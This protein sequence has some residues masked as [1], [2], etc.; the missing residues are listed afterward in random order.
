MGKRRIILESLRKVLDGA[1]P[2]RPELKPIIVNRYTAD[3]VIKLF[4][5]SQRKRSLPLFS[6]LTEPETITIS[7][8]GISAERS[9][10]LIIQ[11][12][13]LSQRGITTSRSSDSLLIGE[14]F[15]DA[16][17]KQLLLQ[18]AVDEFAT[19][20]PGADEEG[21][22]GFSVTAIGPIIVEEYAL[23]GEYVYMSVPLIAEFLEN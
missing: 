9:L 6:I 10:R 19:A 13:L 11:G 8:S 1:I 16:I 7:L 20:F 3:F 17:I 21:C 14:D 5:V 22:N 4:D 2:E 18:D 23:A 12:F 15:V